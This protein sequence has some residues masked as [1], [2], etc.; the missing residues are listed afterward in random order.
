MSA[1]LRGEIRDLLAD[2]RVGAKGHL[3]GVARPV[4]RCS[5]EV[6]VRAAVRDP[7]LGARFRAAGLA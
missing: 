3:L 2:H 1:Y 4:L 5:A 6:A 7:H